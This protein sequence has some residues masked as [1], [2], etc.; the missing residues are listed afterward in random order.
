MAP[1]KPTKASKKNKEPSK[2]K[3]L[4]K[5]RAHEVLERLLAE[6]PSLS[7]AERKAFAARFSA[8]ACEAMGGRTKSEGVLADALE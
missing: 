1:S 7:V 2:P 4:A 3:A 5:T 8:A 6:Q